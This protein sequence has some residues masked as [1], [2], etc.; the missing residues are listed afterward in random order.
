MTCMSWNKK[1]DEIH[2]NFANDT[3]RPRKNVKRVKIGGK[4]ILI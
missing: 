4:F 2:C 1:N 3:C